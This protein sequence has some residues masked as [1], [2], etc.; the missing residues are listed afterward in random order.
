MKTSLCLSTVLLPLFL[1]A[2]TITPEEIA[3]SFRVDATAGTVELAFGSLPTV[4]SDNAPLRSVECGLA[5]ETAPVQLAVF[6]KLVAG[7]P[8][9]VALFNDGTD[10]EITLTAKDAE[11]NT[12]GSSSATAAAKAWTTFA[13]PA[14]AEKVIL[15]I[16]AATGG[17]LI[18]R[19]TLFS[20]FEQILGGDDP[21]ENICYRKFGADEKRS[22]ELLPGNHKNAQGNWNALKPSVRDG[23]PVGVIEENYQPLLVTEKSGVTGASVPVSVPGGAKVVY[24]TYGNP[25]ITLHPE[26]KGHRNSYTGKADQ[27]NYGAFA[28]PVN[29]LDTDRDGV[30]T[31]RLGQEWEHGLTLAQSYGKGEVDFLAIVTANRIDLPENASSIAF[32]FR[33]AK[34]QFVPFTNPVPDGAKAVALLNI[35]P[36]ATQLLW[37]MP[38]GWNG[39]RILRGSDSPYSL[40]VKLDSLKINE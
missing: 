40:I 15:S 1:S 28:L 20:S 38:D 37:L 4:F 12:L 13:F 25:T 2:A 21:I 6:D 22:A 30:W 33:N 26:D 31:G 39:G 14:A 17:A 29:E 35:G 34:G 36:G 18:G 3:G 16:S 10:T 24:R 19:A 9:T 7:R 23:I 5:P 8:F 11:G 27:W 32:E